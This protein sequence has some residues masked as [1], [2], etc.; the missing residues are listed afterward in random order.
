MSTR[1]RFPSNAAGVGLRPTELMSTRDRKSTQRERLLA[2]VVEVINRR[3]YGAATVSAVIAQAG[4]SRPTF[5]D[6]FEDRDDCFRR[7]VE[8]IQDELVADVAASLKARSGSEAASGAVEALISYA[9]AKPA[10]ARFLM[11]ESMSGGADALDARDLG[12]AQLAQLI[13]GAEESVGKDA[14]LADMDARV[15]IGSVY[16]MIATR[17]RRGEMTI[18]KLLDDL[19]EWLCS[20]ARPSSER[21]WQTLSPLPV[22]ARSP[23]VPQL[24][25]QRTPR[26]LPPGRVLLSEHEVGENHRLRILYATARMAE[27]KGY[28][29]T[30]V[31]EITRLASVDG[32]VFYRHFAD[33][34]EAFAAVHEIGFQQ[35]MDVTAKAFFATEG[36]PQ[37][38]WEAARALTGLLQANPLVAHVGFVEAYAGGQATVQRIEDSHTAFMFFL[39]EGL[40]HTKPG[41]T[42]SRVAM[43][44][45]IASVFEV[46]YLQTRGDGELRIAGALPHV[47]H[48]WLTPFLGVDETDDFIDRQLALLLHRG[49]GGD[50]DRGEPGDG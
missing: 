33:K 4:V 23:H 6:Y 14:R 13:Q 11:G 46:I 44:A 18:T 2:G 9:E 49:G 16:R 42:P 19:T 29:A 17:L 40:V 26:V 34:Q 28:S 37:R 38:S 21:R 39:Q 3:G 15:L 47:A 7:A 8:D 27:L 32:R 30:T 50:A 22:G 12:I 10:R 36:W 43:E 25:L 24:P 20:Y 1:I 41:E 5:Y 45:I 35:V 48:L 31:A